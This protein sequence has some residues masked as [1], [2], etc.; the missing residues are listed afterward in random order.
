MSG[1]PRALPARTYIRKG[2]TIISC[3]DK[4][5]RSM[6]EAN[7]EGHLVSDYLGDKLLGMRYVPL[8]DHEYIGTNQ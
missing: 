7:A 6:T 8:A 3:V 1:S 4:Q 2:Q 5:G